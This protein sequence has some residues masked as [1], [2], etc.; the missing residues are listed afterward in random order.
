MQIM[1]SDWD[2]TCYS[3][4]HTTSVNAEILIPSTIIVSELATA[5]LDPLINLELPNLP[6]SETITT[7]SV[8][9]RGVPPPYTWC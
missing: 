7:S 2:S 1:G 5:V 8:A 6:Y 4:V 9:S 3:Q